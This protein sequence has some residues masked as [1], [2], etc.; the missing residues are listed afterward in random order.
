MQLG[1]E[2]RNA[3]IKIAYD[4]LSG[5]LDSISGSRRLWRTADEM[6][7][8]LP[9]E[10]D[11]FVEIDQQ[12]DWLGENT[13]TS[14]WINCEIECKDKVFASCKKLLLYL[15]DQRQETIEIANSVLTGKIGLLE[16]AHLIGSCASD[17]PDIQLLGVLATETDHLPITAQEKIVWNPERLIDKEREISEFEVRTKDEILSACKKIVEKLER[18]EV[19]G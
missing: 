14:E 6:T 4:V 16:G 2:A 9:P 3:I 5:R 12:T 18:Y 8:E 11:L 15:E 7:N 13:R 19:A 17:D 10:F 1:S